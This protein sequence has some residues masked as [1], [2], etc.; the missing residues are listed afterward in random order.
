MC[1]YDPDMR[2]QSMEHVLNDIEGIVTGEEVRDK[3]ENIKSIYVAAYIFFVA[4]VAFLKLTKLPDYDIGISI[5]GYIFLIGVIGKFILKVRGK[6][7]EFIES[8]LFCY[9]IYLSIATGFTWIK[10]IFLLL[11]SVEGSSL[12]V[13][14]CIGIIFL[15]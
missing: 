15:T 2:Y 3:K 12:G 14:A 10:L 11:L 7:I 9:A 8:V 6:N 1:M 13:V 4:G 5:K